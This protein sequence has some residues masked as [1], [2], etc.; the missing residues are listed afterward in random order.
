MLFAR[1]KCTDVEHDDYNDNKGRLKLN[2]DH[3]KAH[4]KA[5]RSPLAEPVSVVAIFRLKGSS[6][7][8]H[9]FVNHFSA[10]DGQTHA[11]M[12]ASCD[13]HGSERGK[14]L[15]GRIE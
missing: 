13:F 2:L 6:A 8:L 10:G 4:E 7:T 5:G 12:Q 9:V 14:I 1:Q 11:E 15:E 3:S